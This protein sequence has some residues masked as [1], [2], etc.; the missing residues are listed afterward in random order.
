MLLFNQF[1]MRITTVC[2]LLFCCLKQAR[3]QNYQSID[4]IKAPA[5]FENI[6]SR[7][8]YTDSLVSSFVI[9]IKK[10]VKS[11]KHLTHA[12]HVV[13]LEGSGNMTLGEKMFAVK[14]G[15]VVF[16]P[17]NTR[18]SVQTTS[19]IPLK[20]LSVQA[21]LFDGKDRVFGD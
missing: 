1:F 20:V 4:T 12:E 17:K 13:V 6:Y 18:H 3:S 19:T 21:P 15:D 8:L 14:K 10:E 9:F 16:I 2:L 11:H 7:A 5:E